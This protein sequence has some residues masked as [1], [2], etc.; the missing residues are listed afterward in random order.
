MKQIRARATIGEREREKTLAN[1][2]PE[3]GGAYRWGETNEGERRDK[4]SC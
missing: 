1:S 2:V 4:K 3:G